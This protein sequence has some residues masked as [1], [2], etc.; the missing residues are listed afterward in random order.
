MSEVV[1]FSLVMVVNVFIASCSQILL[2]RSATKSHDNIVA[3]Y[4]NWRVI[5]AYGLF[6]L[7]AV[8]GM[9]VLRHIPLSSMPI[10]ESTG[11]I[12]IAVLSY[13]FLQEK[14]SKGQL[15][16]MLLIILGIFIFSM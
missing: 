15:F 14:L 4:L 10:L 3:E 5:V 7:T 1:V 12:F 16:G 8:V 6:G 2:K 11:Y 13:F 9:Y